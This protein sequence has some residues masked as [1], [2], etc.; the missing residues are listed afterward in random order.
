LN[1]QLIKTVTN[2]S[3][4]TVRAALTPRSGSPAFGTG[5]G[6]KYDKGGL[7]PP[8]LLVF[9]E[10]I[11][12]TTNTSATL[13]VAPIEAWRF[14]SGVP[15]YNSGYPFYK[16]KLDN[17]AWSAELSTTNSATISLSGLSPGPHTVYVSGKNDA[18]YYQDDPFLYPT[19]SGIPAHITA[20]RTWIVTNSPGRVVF[21][22]ILARNATAFPHEDE[23]P[24][25]VELFNPG[26][27]PVSLGGKGITSDPTQDHYKFIFPTNTVLGPGQY[28]LVFADS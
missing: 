27:S 12:E 15:P 11:G 5:F 24:D 3:A 25:V 14:G 22:E 1:L 8:G 13:T 16:W 4:A 10:P 2:A 7:N 20:S 17:G 18:G 9:G 23:S 26:A 21:N 6:A 19:N 28:L